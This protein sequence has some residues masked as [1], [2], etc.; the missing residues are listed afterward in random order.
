MSPSTSFVA[1]RPRPTRPPRAEDVLAPADAQELIRRRHPLLSGRLY[2][3]NARSVFEHTMTASYGSHWLLMASGF[4]EPVL[5][6]LSMG[7][8]V[9]ALVGRIDYH[10]QALPYGA[11]IAPALLAT[12]AMNGAIYDSTWNVFFKLRFSKVYESMLATP[13]GPL[14]VAL[15]EIGTA[16]FRGVLYSCSFMVLMQVLGYN[17]AWTAVLAVPA[18]VLIAFGFAALGM[19]V[20]SFCTSFVQMDWIQIVLLPMFLLS[21]TFFPVTV[22]PPVLQGVVM[23]FP[24]WHGV[25]LVRMLTTGTI[26]AGILWHLGYFLV[27]AG[28]GVLAVTRRLRALFLS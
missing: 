28:I 27:M 8:G 24:L 1:R 13:L 17:L 10:G 20:T 19:A 5:Y 21:A 11:Y 18:C 23:A 9:G 14:D 26:D 7:I 2:A 25:E 16:L 15:G 22:Y 3:G 6:L 4:L 12:S